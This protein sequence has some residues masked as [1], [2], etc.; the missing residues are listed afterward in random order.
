[1]QSCGLRVDSHRVCY[2]AFVFLVLCFFFFSSSSSFSC[3]KGFI[4]LLHF[5]VSAS[6]S[7]YDL[8][9]FSPPSYSN[10]SECLP[11]FGNW[12]HPQRSIRLLLTFSVVVLLPLVLPLV[13]SFLLSIDP[14]SSDLLASAIREIQS[15]IHLLQV[16]EK[17]QNLLALFADE[18]TNHLGVWSI[19]RFLLGRLDPLCVCLSV[20][21]LCFCSWVC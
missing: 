6:F 7:L 20:Y 11:H 19:A 10:S 9:V 3:Y 18:S 15:N 21:V 8:G 1:M 5:F 2:C 12:G 4:L 16:S 17:L 14:G 13:C